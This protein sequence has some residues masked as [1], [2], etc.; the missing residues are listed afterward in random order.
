VVKRHHPRQRSCPTA[1]APAGERRPRSAAA[2]V[3]RQ[4][5]AN[6]Q[7][8]LCPEK[9]YRPRRCYSSIVPQTRRCSLRGRLA[10]PFARESERVP[11]RNRGWRS[12]G[13]RSSP[14]SQRACFVVEA[15]RPGASRPAPYPRLRR[16]TEPTP[17]R[18]RDE[19]DELDVGV[20]PRG[21]ST[22]VQDTRFTRDMIVAVVALVFSILLIVYLRNTG[23]APGCTG[24]R[25]FSPA[26]PSYSVSPYTTR[27]PGG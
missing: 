27:S 16:H 8:P 14:A 2:Y 5:R 10:S 25:S 26:A 24:H 15:G 7:L 4:P 17:S 23:D 21:R 11:D 18:K 19:Q 3:A 1:H 13:R 20:G 12:G 9:S 22:N 6:R